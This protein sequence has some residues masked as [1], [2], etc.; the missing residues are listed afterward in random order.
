[1]VNNDKTDCVMIG[2]QDVTAGEAIME[3][4]IEYMGSEEFNIV[5]I[6]VLWDNRHS[7]SVWRELQMY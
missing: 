2:S 1:M 7:Y 5:V 4:M 6:E 3:Y